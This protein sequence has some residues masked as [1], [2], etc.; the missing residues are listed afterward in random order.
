VTRE[1][2]AAAALKLP[3]RKRAELASQLIRSL[4]DLPESEWEEV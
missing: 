2:V 3:R 1:D 4:G